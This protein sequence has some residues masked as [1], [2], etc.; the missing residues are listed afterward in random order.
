[1]FVMD[2]EDPQGITAAKE[3]IAFLVSTLVDEGFE[4]AVVLASL[5]SCAG[6]LVGI[7]FD[8]EIHSKII[9][10]M[11]SPMLKD[12]MNAHDFNKNHSGTRN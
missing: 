12:A 10:D 8:T 5:G 2:R 7:L 9:D 6:N 3:R 4:P 11:K 1:M